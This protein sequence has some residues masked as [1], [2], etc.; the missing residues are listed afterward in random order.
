MRLKQQSKTHNLIMIALRNFGFFSA[1]IVPLAAAI[2]PDLHAQ[3]PRLVTHE[4]SVVRDGTNYHGLG[5]FKFALI[6]PQTQTTWWSSSSTT[7]GSFAPPTGISLRVFNGVYQVDLGDTNLFNMAALPPDVFEK[8][9]LILRVWFSDGISPLMPIQPD[10]RITSSPYAFVAGTVVD[11]SVSAA[12]LAPGAVTAGAIAAGAIGSAQL[13]PGAVGAAQLSPEAVISTLNAAGGMVVSAQPGNTNLLALGLRSV[14]SMTVA[15]ENWQILGSYCPSPRALHAAVWMDTEMFICGG[16]FDPGVQTT[17]TDAAGIYDGATDTWRRLPRAMDPPSG[18]SVLRAIWTGHEIILWAG[19]AYGRILDPKSGAWRMIANTGAP[20]SSLATATCT[21]TEREMVILGG[22]ARHAFN[23]A[24]GK[25]RLL[26]S[27]PLLSNRTSHTAVWT[28]YELLVWGG[29]RDNVAQNSGLRYDPVNEQWLVITNRGAP[30]ARLDHTAVWT[31]K[32]MLVWGGGDQSIGRSLNTGGAY[33]PSTDTWRLLNTNTAPRL[34]HTAV[35]TGKAMLVLGGVSRDPSKKPTEPLAASLASYDP[36]ADAWSD[37]ALPPLEAW[38]DYTA[39][40]SG[41]EL[42]VWGGGQVNTQSWSGPVLSPFSN[43]GYRY[44][45]VGDSWAPMALTPAYRTGAS[46]VWTG[47][48]LLLWGGLSAPATPYPLASG[49]RYNPMTG[50]WRPISSRGAPTA[51]REQRAVW[52]GKHM[53]VWGGYSGYNRRTDTYLNTGA[54]YD[55][56]AD[57]WLPMETN[58]APHG[59]VDFSMVWSG[60]EVIV[61]GGSYYSTRPNP[62]DPGFL[63]PDYYVSNGGRYDPEKDS[64]TSMS[65]VGAASPR[66]L[67]AAVWANDEMIV[68]GGA[69]PT[70]SPPIIAPRLNWLTNGAR[71]RPD[72]NLWRPMSSLG[73]TG[74]NTNALQVVWTGREMLVPGHGPR[75][76]GLAR[77]N[78]ASD[79]WTWSAAKSSPLGV[80][81]ASGVWSDKEAYFFPQSVGSTPLCHYDPV[82]D[83]WTRVMET[84]SPNR[85]MLYPVFWAGEGL[86]AYDAAEKGSIPTLSRILHYRTTLPLYLYGK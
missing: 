70:W 33:Q 63:S 1:L 60:K 27:H 71:Y 50:K 8:G 51:R 6:D 16:R 30:A 14:G 68:W 83:T 4:G 86:L 46:L 18:T 58:G 40:W 72:Q 35:W 62:T 57:L 19:P 15:A 26:P 37:R 31:G 77:Y 78:P 34:G 45:P 43:A 12:K 21:W 65:T 64:W 42:L 32:E 69:G 82:A 39:V 73:T 7:P 67:H 75:G 38:R 41:Q 5:E 85:P 74:S 20:E 55:P 61:F 52:T 11:G 81:S 54:R 56:A 44:N 47:S 59:V 28:G 17:S 9:E 84:Q 22:T 13:A 23:P 80:A 25:W 36:Q 3:V 49:A 29:K 10:T 48:E 53:V 76:P 2:V 66:S 79:R 24:T